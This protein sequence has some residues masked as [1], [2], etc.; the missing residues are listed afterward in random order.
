MHDDFFTIGGH[1]L[2][3][4]RVL[5]LLKEDFS[6]LTIQDFF[7][8]RTIYGLARIEREV[9]VEKEE[10]FREYKVIHEPDTITY[11]N[12]LEETQISNVFLT[13]A[14]GYLGSHII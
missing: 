8:E 9:K 13:G 11:A 1:S 5:T 6:H 3:V 10:V 7:K 4:L 2:K 14:T 12:V